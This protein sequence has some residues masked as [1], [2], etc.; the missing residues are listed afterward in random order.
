MGTI[1]NTCKEMLILHGAPVGK[2]KKLNSVLLHVSTA[3]SKRKSK[4]RICISCMHPSISLEMFVL[5]YFTLDI[6]SVVI[7][8]W[9]KLR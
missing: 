4:K 8:I 2:T 7:L 9:F 3:V 5:W 1:D 6:V